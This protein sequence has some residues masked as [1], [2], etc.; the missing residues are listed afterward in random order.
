MGECFF[1]FWIFFQLNSCLEDFIPYINYK[2]K[3][4]CVNFHLPQSKSVSIFPLSPQTELQWICRNS[5]SMIGSSLFLGPQ[6]RH[7]D[8]LSSFVRSLSGR[9]VIFRRGSEYCCFFSNCE[10]C[11]HSKQEIIFGMIHGK[12]IYIEEI[13]KWYK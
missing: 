4:K 1:S 7:C 10:V 9:R 2:N 3:W 12:K 5:T 8:I 13:I 11:F 6:K